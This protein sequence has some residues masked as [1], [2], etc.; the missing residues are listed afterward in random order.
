VGDQVSGGSS[1]GGSSSGGSSSG[2]SN[3]GSGG[4]SSGASNTAASSSSSTAQF[5]VI[6][7]KKWTV[8]S[9]VDATEVGLIAKGDQAQ[10][11]IDGATGTVYGTIS[12]VGIV[13]SSSSSGTSSSSASYPVDVAVT[14]NP[15]GLHAGTSATVALIYKQ[16]ANVLTLPSLAVQQVNGTS[17]VYVSSNGTATGKRVTTKVTTGLS[18][19]GTVQI[20]SGLKTGA[21]V[22]VQVA[23]PLTRGTGTGT[24]TG[25]GTGTR[26]GFGGG[27]FGGG[28]GNFG[29]GTGNFGGGNVGGGAV[30]GGG[31]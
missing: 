29:G 19:G 22:L 13:A 15:S 25:E 20:K 9:S 14:G 5:L 4:A 8:T 17:V 24:G 26:G 7:T 16:L 10:L 28:A 30:G 11:T 31:R 2:G 23:S 27:N 21:V 1:S 3:G 6:S 18:S 12:S